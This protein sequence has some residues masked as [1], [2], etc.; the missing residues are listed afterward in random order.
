ML[1]CNVP[2]NPKREG[3]YDP[4]IRPTK[5]PTVLQANLLD[6]LN[7]TETHRVEFVV[8]V[9]ITPTGLGWTYLNHR[10]LDRETVGHPWGRAQ[11]YSCP[12]S[13]PIRRLIFYNLYYELTKHVM[14]IYE[15][16]SGIAA[17]SGVSSE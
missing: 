10:I 5:D 12:V 2:I 1:I 16:P 15:I 3:V 8:K 6:A 4:V 9:E 14:C 17:I 7:S 11:Y 13:E